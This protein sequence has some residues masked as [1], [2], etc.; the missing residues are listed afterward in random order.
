MALNAYETWKELEADAEESLIL[1]TGGLD[2]APAGAIIPINQYR[3]SLSAR[4]IPFEWLDTKEVMYR[5][6]QWRLTEDIGGLYQAEGGIAPAAKCM[7]AH[8]RLARAHGAQIREDA[9]VTK[10]T[11]C[12]GSVTL[13]AGGDTY[14]C[15]HLVIAAGAWSN[16]MLRLLDSEIPL[17]ITKS[18]SSILTPRGVRIC[19]RALSIWI[20]M[21][22]PCYYGFPTYG[23]P[24]PKAA[25]DAGGREV[26]PET[27]TFEPDE[28][29]RDRLFNFTQTFLPTMGTR[30][31]YIKTC[32]YAM[33]PDRD[34]VLT[35]L[36]RYPNISVGIGAG[37][38]FKFSSL[39]GKALSE[40]AVDG[41]S[42]YDLAP[43][44][45]D[46]PILLEENPANQFMTW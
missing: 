24:G 20:W 7:A 22:D 39:L 33:P 13:V 5:W 17:T 32:L 23:E 27:R 10:I 46:R 16:H 2:L 42:Q 26:D 18:R 38:A 19:A 12:Q 9:P 45:I 6:P 3:D 21:D 28:A 31:L 14:S 34:F 25:Q 4:E 35:R 1:R 15:R 43:F 8:L 11:S 36:P 40:L 44:A 37:H 30:P 29:A 41:K